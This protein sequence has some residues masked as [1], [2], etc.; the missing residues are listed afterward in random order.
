MKEI[1]CKECKDTYYEDLFNECPYC[2]YG[3]SKAELKILPRK[4]WLEL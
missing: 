1:K 3:I 4:K 2:E